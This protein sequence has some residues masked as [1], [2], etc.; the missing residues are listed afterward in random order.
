MF[1][2]IIIAIGGVVGMMILWTGIQALWRKVFS[3]HIVE[4]DVLAGRTKCG[5]CGCVTVCRDNGK[6]LTEIEL[7]AN[8]E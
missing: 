7:Q 6:H 4:E 2:T 1:E 5:N 8:Q 3:D